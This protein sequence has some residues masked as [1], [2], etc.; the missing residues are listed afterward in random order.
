MAYEHVYRSTQKKEGDELERHRG[1][2]AQCTLTSGQGGQH[3]Q[4]CISTRDVISNKKG[5]NREPHSG[6]GE[7]SVWFWQM[8]GFASTAR[9]IDAGTAR[10]SV[11]FKAKILDSESGARGVPKLI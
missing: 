11:L 3:V 10:D 8:H 7:P 6:G 5:P 4:Y 9:R 2:Y 1:S